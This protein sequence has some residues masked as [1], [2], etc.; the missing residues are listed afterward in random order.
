MH[1]AGYEID[2][3]LSRYKAGVCERERQRCV[4]HRWHMYENAIRVP[5][6]T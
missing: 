3:P 5:H 2:I 4:H 6:N 1:A